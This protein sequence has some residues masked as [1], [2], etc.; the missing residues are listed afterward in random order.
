MGTLD[1]TTYVS[2]SQVLRSKGM[3]ASARTLKLWLSRAESDVLS[4]PQDRDGLDD[5]RRLAGEAVFGVLPRFVGA[6]AS[7]SQPPGK[8]VLPV[9]L[10]QG[11]ELPVQI[12]RDVGSLEGG[13][14]DGFFAA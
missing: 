6:G 5:R 13:D 7:G 1:P 3:E 11:E 10:F 4:K 8:P 9:E 14:E 12:I 2:P